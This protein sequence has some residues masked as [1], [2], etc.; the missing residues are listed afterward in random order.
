MK[1]VRIHEFGGPE[2]LKIEEVPEPTLAPGDVLIQTE[3]AGVNYADVMTRVGMYPIKGL[4]ITPG[5]EVAGRVVKTGG[6]VT[7]F[8]A[9]DR[10]VATL[11]TGGYAERVAAPAAT[12]FSVP[13]SLSA[14][15]AAALPVN[16]LTALHMLREFGRLAPGE[17]VLIHAAASG[18]G[19]AAI[20]LAR[21]FGARIFATASADDKLALARELGA[22]ETIN[23]TTQD[24]AEIV[25]AKTDGR[26]VDLILE[27]VG[28]DVFDKSIQCLAPLGRLITYGVAGGVPAT[29]VTPVLLF[30]NLSVIGFHLGR[31]YQT[32]PNREGMQ[33][34]LRLVAAGRIRPIIS[35]TFPLGE[36]AKAHDHLSQRQTRGKVLLVP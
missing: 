20:Q 34:I 19:T 8:K 3:A 11:N 28:G 23:Y 26:G 35:A 4:P 6:A 21:L 30:G 10:V 12:V 33:E 16:Y 22:H 17:S 9:G 13:E 32:R 25:K 2:V 27:C 1:A 14:V 7:D 24:F 5:L 29:V 31:Y 15:Q 18:V 36:V